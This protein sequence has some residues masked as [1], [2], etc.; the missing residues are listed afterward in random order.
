[1]L[2]ELMVLSQS[3]YVSAALFA[4][5]HGALGERAIALD[6]IDTVIEERAPAVA[7]MGVRPVFDGLRKE[8]RFAAACLRVGVPPYAEGAPR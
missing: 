8:A 2:G 5:I 3:R 1:V 6:R 4:Q 7:W